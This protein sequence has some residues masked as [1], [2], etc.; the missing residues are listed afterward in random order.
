[1]SGKVYLVDGSSYIFRAF[2]AVAPLTNSAGFPTNALYGYTRMLRKL[3]EQANSGHVA[4]VFDPGG[5]TFRHELYPEYKANRT[6]C[7]EELS[8]QMP[9][10]RELTAALGIPVL[11]Q[12]GYEADDVIGALTHRLALAN[13]E[14]VLVSGDKDLM[15]LVGEHISMWDTMKDKRYGVAEVQAKFGV[16][17]SKVVEVLALMGDSSDNIPGLKGV[18]P[19]TATQLIEKYGDIETLMAK[20]EDLLGDSS[21]RS[22]KKVYAALEAEQDILRLSRKLVE[23]DG[24][25][26]LVFEQNGNSVTLADLDDSELYNFLERRDPH[27]EELR[28]LV[29]RFEFSSLLGDLDLKRGHEEVELDADYDYCCILDSAFDTWLATLKAQPFFAFDIETT[30]LDPFE[31]EIVG[32][33]FC[34]SAERAYYVP[35]GHRGVEGSVDQLT[36]EQLLAAV[37][38]ILADPNVHKCGQNLKFDL[39]VLGVKGIEVAGVCFDSMLASYLLNPD[40]RNHKLST[41]ANSYLA[42]SMREYEEVVGD[43]GGFEFVPLDRATHYACA[44]AHV[45]WQLQL[46]MLPLLQDQGLDRVMTEIEAPLVPVLSRMERAGIRLDS[47]LLV[48]MSDQFAVELEQIQTR[49]FELAGE[50]FNLNSPKQL[51]HILFDKLGIPTKGL[52]KTKTGVSTNQVVLESLSHNYE[53]A[54]YILRNRLVHKLKT[55]YV[56]ALPAQVSPY[57]ERLHSSFNQAVTATGRLSS[58]DPNLQN[59]PISSA[60][61]RRIREAFIPADGS[62]LISA[63]YSQIELRLLAHLSGDENLKRAFVEGADIHAATAR[64]ILGI[65]ADQDV[66]TD[67]RR[68]GKTI[69]FGVIYGMG[70]FRLA[71]DLGISQSQAKQY[72]ENYF[73]RYSEVRSYFEQL[74]ADVAAAGAVSTMFGRKRYIA[75][76]DTSGRDSGFA[77]RAAM[78]APIQGSAADIIKL[79]MIELDR[80]I[81]DDDLPMRLVLQVHDELVFECE[82]E[83]HQHLLPIVVEVMENVVQLDVPLKVDAAWGANWGQA[84]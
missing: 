59:I 40:S 26:P 71:R 55:T 76:L 42:R 81:R 16:P 39:N 77:T 52:K 47:A 79:A 63:D 13:I 50:E 36:K 32:M 21:I 70:P 27:E 35:V 58:S 83:S 17:P 46:H 73:T 23:I 2:Y 3:L 30:A 33:S 57:T 7:P 8:V 45:A 19:K 22:R 68:I 18:G 48:E 54:D 31:A 41:L 4:V 82:A 84:H 62:V 61:G 67:Q 38:P 51:Q 74:E 14:T 20:R 10:F 43:A 6:E 64:E 29:D 44:D 11:E 37:A 65:A 15:Q 80:R 66:G 5:K 12:A 1:M 24:S 34:W 56:D 53:I 78:N 60:E 9:Y 49:V 72:I 25:T 69:N 28:A 75:E